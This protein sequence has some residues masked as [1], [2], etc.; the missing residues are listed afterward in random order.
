MLLDTWL[1][2]CRV[3]GRQVESTTLNLVAQLARD[4][5]ARRLVGEYIPTTKNAM[6]RD[7]Y[8]K[9]GF[10]PTLQ[11]PGGRSL[12]ELSLDGWAPVPTFIAVSEGQ[13]T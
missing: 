7:H 5:G 8:E 13:E 9:L 3:L 1:M 2:S 6:V 10:A 4:M 12:A 11:E